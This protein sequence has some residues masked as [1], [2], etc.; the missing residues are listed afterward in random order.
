MRS[1]ILIVVGTT[2][3]SI[4]GLSTHRSGRGLGWRLPGR[5]LSGLPSWISARLGVDGAAPLRFDYGRLLL[6]GLSSL[7]RCTVISVLLSLPSL[8]PSSSALSASWVVVV[9]RS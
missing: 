2:I 9:M 7:R 4:V 6:P 3:T 1:R 8:W 5:G